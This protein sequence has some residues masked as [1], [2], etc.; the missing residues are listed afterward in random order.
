[1]LVRPG[2]YSPAATAGTQRAAPA[3]K[4]KQS[5]I[6]G[7]SSPRARAGGLPVFSDSRFANASA[8]FSSWSATWSSFA[9]RSC[10]VVR[11]HAGKAASAAAT[12][13]S[14]CDSDASGTLA[15]RSPVAGFTIVSAAPSPATKRPLIR[16]CVCMR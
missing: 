16:S 7:S 15:I 4:R 8:S 3:K 14:I 2:R 6:A 12:A 13:P 11:A 9:A 1:M 5:T 10:G